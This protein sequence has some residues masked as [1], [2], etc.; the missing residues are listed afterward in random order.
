M[1]LNY[2]FTMP[3]KVNAYVSEDI[4][5]PQKLSTIVVFFYSNF[6]VLQ[7]E[8]GR[9]VANCGLEMAINFQ[10]SFVSNHEEQLLS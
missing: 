2:E 8:N 6:L 5:S 1:K 7:V 3:P 4:A 10:N 9:D